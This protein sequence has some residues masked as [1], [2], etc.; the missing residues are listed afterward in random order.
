[1]KEKIERLFSN[2]YFETIMML[3]FVTVG[4]FIRLVRFGD[5]PHGVHQDEASAAVDALALSMYGTD[6]WGMRFP[7]HFT[8]WGD[9]QMS[10]LL[11]YCMVPFIKLFGFSTPVIRL[12]LLIISMLGLIALFYFVRKQSNA[13][14]AF[15]TLFMMII[16][17]WHYM[18]S[19]WSIDCNMYPH[20]FLIA[21]LLLVLGFKKKWC[22]YLSMVVYGLSVYAYAT[23][24][25]S[26]PLFL[27][28]VALFMVREKI[29][30]W[31]EVLISIVI[32]V[33]VSLP[34]YI[35]MAINV[36]GWET[37]E[38]PFFTMPRFPESTR[39]NDILF[40]NFSFKQAWANFTQYLNVVWW[41]GDFTFT[42]TT[43][44]LGP[45][46]HGTTFFFII[47]LAVMIIRSI[48]CKFHNMF[49][50]IMI[51]WLL[52]TTWVGVLTNGPVIHRIN[53]AFYM[54]VIIA[55]IGIEWIFVKSK[56]V[57]SGV[58]LSY[59]GVGLYFAY[60]YFIAWAPIS[61]TYY[62][63][64]Y[65]DAVKAA[66]DCDCDYYYIRT[67]PQ[68]DPTDKDYYKLGEILTMYAHK[69]DAHYFQGLTDIQDGKEVLPYKE[70]YI[71][72]YVNDDVVAEYA[73][74]K[75][76]YVIR[77]EEVGYFN[78]DDYWV[79]GHGKYFVVWKK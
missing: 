69:M 59:A 67:N 39:A 65:L 1:M 7:V 18:Q 33:L 3:L 62:Y 21:T 78:Y 51:A 23:A 29:I 68:I 44:N 8:A 42:S 25:Y 20:M 76:A 6:K 53:I 27:L 5:I 49:Y 37:I 22:L 48:K 46:Y 11:S 34:E 24:D 79:G 50:N 43:Q 41:K 60:V 31:K 45:I 14:L 74:K 30:G 4:L 63:H 35:T 40:T 28:I 66:Q 61:Y 2:K 9:S 54:V 56:I 17:P 71:Y 57:F 77:Q 72:G 13:V 52:L 47:G 32:F 19:L 73:D 70:R 64:D 38:T 36:F 10:V 55:S 16:N 12:P 26:L 75:V 58:M 15:V